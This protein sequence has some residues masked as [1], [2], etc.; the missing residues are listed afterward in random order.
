MSTRWSLP[1]AF[2]LTTVAGALLRPKRRSHPPQHLS[3]PP[4]RFQ[5]LRSGL[6]LDNFDRRVRPQD[7]LFRFVNGGWLARTEI[8]ADKSNYGAF[9]LLRTTPRRTCARSSKRKPRPGAP[10]GSDQQLI[11]DFY[12]SFMDEARPRSSASRRWSRN[13]TRIDAIKDRGQ[14]RRLPRPR[15]GARHRQLRSTARDPADAKRPGRQHDLADQAG[16]GMPERDYYLEQGREL[17]RRSRAKYD[18]HIAQGMKRS[19]A[20]RTAPRCAKARHGVRDAARRRR[21]GQPSKLRDVEQALQPDVDVASRQRRRRPASTG[22]DGSPTWAS[23]P[24]PPDRL[25]Q[26]SYFKA[27]GKALAA[28]CRSRRGRTT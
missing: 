17:R 12:A 8:P 13:S 10:A 20:A 11:G 21:P 7:D 4:P 14:L 27:V 5:R 2:A 26:P 9:T 3:R 15:A 28:T 25:A 22:R 1:L 16:L 23:R 24:R 19:Q 6:F 18:A